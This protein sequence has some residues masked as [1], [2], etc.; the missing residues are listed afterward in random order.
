MP[1]RTT[2]SVPVRMQME[3]NEGGAVCLAMILAYYGRWEPLEVV[4]AA[5]AIDRDGASVEDVLRA[6]RFWGL[7]ARAEQCSAKDLARLD[8]LPC[9][10]VWNEVHFVVLKQISGDHAYLNDP[11]C[12]TVRIS[13]EKLSHAFSGTALLMSPTD[14]FVQ[15]GRPPSIVDFARQRMR[16]M[17][18]PLA[19]VALSTLVISLATIGSTS[20]SS[21]FLDD[22][23]S[24]DSPG[25]MMPLI[26]GLTV[27]VVMRAA[28]SA[29]RANC[30]N[31][32]KG[33]FA[34]VSSSRF[35]WHL[36][37]LPLEFFSQRGAADL[38]QRQESNAE[39]G[40]ILFEEL[41]P[42]L[43]NVA[44]LVLYLGVM[45]RISL[46]LTAVGLA[47]VLI[48]LCLGNAISRRRLN[49]TR[50]HLREDAMYFEATVEGI[51][52]I[53]TI[54]AAGSEDA[55]FERWAGFQANV[56]ESHEH[57]ERTNIYLGSL[58]AFV[59]AFANA[60]ILI[61][62]TLLIMNGNFTAGAL[63]AFHGYMQS[64]MA[65]V[66]GVIGL[67]QR[68]QEIRSSVERVQDVMEYPEE[69]VAPVAATPGE[70]RLTGAIELRG[71]TYGYS[72]FM[73]PLI[74]DFSLKLSPGS[75]VA[76]VGPSGSGKSTIARIIGGLVTPWEGDVLFDDMPIATIPADVLR[77]SLA[78]VNQ[79]VV[80]F[81]D[82]VE[83]N[84]RL[85]DATID[86]YEVVMAAHDADIHDVIMERPYGYDERVA[87]NGTN[88]SGGQLQRLEIA[89]VLA[90]EPTIVI[91]DEATSA[92]D[93]STEATV[94]D[95]IRKRGVTCVMAAHRLS[96]VRDADE[97]I[98]LDHGRVVERGTHQ[99][100]M[101]LD[102]VYAD[103]VRSE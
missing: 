100:L 75:W 76:I 86:D 69:Q 33:K 73:P 47:C 57:M 19:F 79:E 74:Q 94:M 21:L 24:G 8:G 91:L 87:P 28:V 40:T 61:L 62:G 59:T 45:S 16:G 99:Y 5:C 12:G 81:D 10:L 6:A 56:A 70:G 64:F 3:N 25:W 55:Y 23:L 22:V 29:V 85:W 44:L 97:I 67:A 89:R 78:G 11:A 65:P 66:D 77:G 17:R 92:L 43:L 54:K 1:R 49:A 27:F 88:F 98:V 20:L 4:R 63:L 14:D 102:G 36:L 32:I 41:A 58:P 71:V 84:I 7:D 60:S 83:E 18:A 50:Q 72:R 35:M 42:T 101:D 68:A 95:A 82:T 34:V 80:T 51:D 31:R 93:A 52:A 46:P 38:Q 37:H 53:E 13:L 15:G 48:N 30:V 2:G 90:Q 39:I 96:A 26:A 9:I 103:L